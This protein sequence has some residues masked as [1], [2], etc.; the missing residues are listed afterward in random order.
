[1][2][3]R[4]FFQLVWTLPV[5]ALL[6]GCQKE[7]GIS[8]EQEPVK[9]I[10][11]IRSQAAS[12]NE[13][14]PQQAYIG[15]TKGDGETLTYTLEV[16][17]R[18]E[19]PRCMLHKSENGS[20]TGGVRFEIAL[21]P[22]SYD[23][24][25]WSDYGKGHYQT[26]NLRQVTVNTDSYDTGAGNDAF[27]CVLKDMA[28]DGNAVCNATL[29]RPV[30]RINIRNTQNFD[31]AGSVSIIYEEIYT[32]YDVLTGEVSAP[33]QDLAVSCPDTEAGSAQVAEDFLFVPEKETVSFSVSAN[34]TTK[35]V[36]NVPL[37]SNYNTNIT[38]SL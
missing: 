7:P 27:S 17:T 35:T 32:V 21:I 26:S 24:L 10:I 29:K 8:S 15:E 30:A 19:T 25:F 11:S 31:S 34:G 2:K 12:E 1:M 3:A 38:C 13:S 28:W 33:Y 22:G 20:L 37:K 36:E 18:E 14:G 5:L 9:G 6:S 16:W 23:F 4:R